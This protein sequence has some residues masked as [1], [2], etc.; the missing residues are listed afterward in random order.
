MFFGH[1]VQTDDLDENGIGIPANALSANGVRIRDHAGNDADLRHPAV[2]DDPRY[3][4]DG[5]LHYRLRLTEVAFYSVPSCC[6][7]YLPGELII[8]VVSFDQ[9]ISH[10]DG[11]TSGHTWS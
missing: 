6:E 3:K 2:A 8:A 9:A 5:R 4:V 7:T 1:R 11:A 10:I